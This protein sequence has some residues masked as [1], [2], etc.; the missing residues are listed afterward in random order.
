[1]NM[2]KANRTNDK[3]RNNPYRIGKK[4][5]DRVVREIQGKQQVNNNEF[6][7]LQVQDKSLENMVRY[8]PQM[9]NIFESKGD[10]VCYNADIA[11]LIPKGR[12]CLLWFTVYETQNVCYVIDC[13]HVNSHIT[14]KI[15][16]NSYFAIQTSFD[17]SLCHGDGTVLRGTHCKINNKFVCAIED[18]YYYKGNNL[19][20]KNLYDRLN[21]LSQLFQYEVDQKRYFEKQ[22]ILTLCVSVSGSMQPEEITRQVSSLPYPVQFIQ[23]RY[24]NRK[25]FQIINVPPDVYTNYILT[26][27]K[28]HYSIPNQNRHQY[29]N[30]QQQTLHDMVFIVTPDI[31]N[32]IYKLHTYDPEEENNRKFYSYAGIQSYD[33]SVMMNK[34]FRDIKENRNLDLLEESDDEEDF[35]NIA[36]DKYVK[37]DKS[38]KMLCTYMPKFNKWLPVKTVGR[39]QRVA[40]E[41]DLFGIG[42]Y[43]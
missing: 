2:N 13:M 18:I 9:S 24:E 37:L 35:E 12:R 22:C 5:T 10:Q 3:F 43:K 7:V 32:D 11:M 33:A 15:Q 14:N 42:K 23:F 8:F 6:R 31:Q 16:R 19:R 28:N 38:Y 41:K 20:D 25:Q 36:L 1:M 29:N 26:Q 39:E 30:R 40:M 34:L 17:T 21:C 27:N 4:K